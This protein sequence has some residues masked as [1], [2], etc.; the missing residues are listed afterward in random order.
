MPTPSYHAPESIPEATA[1]LNDSKDCRILA[2]GTDLLVQMR[3]GD[4]M[5]GA[6]DYRRKAVGVMVR[7]AALIARDG[8]INSKQVSV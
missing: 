4:A 3:G 1:L 2:G 7:R 8:A 5:P 6:A